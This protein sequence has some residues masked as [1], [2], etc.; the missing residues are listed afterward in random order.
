MSLTH[1]K[2]FLNFLNDLKMQNLNHF[3]FVYDNKL[4][5]KLVTSTQSKNSVDS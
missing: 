1:F 2:V 4:T 3:L 5:L